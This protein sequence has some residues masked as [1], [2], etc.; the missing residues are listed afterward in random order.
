MLGMLSLFCQQVPGL[1]ISMNNHHPLISLQIEIIIS[2]WNSLECPGN[3]KIQPEI[4]T[5]M[6]F[7]H[8]DHLM[9]PIVIILIEID[10][11]IFS[12][13]SLEGLIESITKFYVVLQEIHS[14]LRE[15]VSADKRSLQL[16]PWASALFEFLPPFIR[17]QVLKTIKNEL[18][19]EVLESWTGS[20]C[21]P[22]NWH[23]VKYN[24]SNGTV[25]SI[26]RK[27]SRTTP[28]EHHYADSSYGIVGKARTELNQ[29]L[30]D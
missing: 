9:K 15:G 19:N 20:P 13:K 12:N 4:I 28:T 26:C 10:Q 3:C 16:S 11:I 27:I 18:L 8:L 24:Q 5:S 2:A 6:T 29:D 17:K 7:I 30:Q 25:G 23:G 1:Q 22:Q 21:L 14:L